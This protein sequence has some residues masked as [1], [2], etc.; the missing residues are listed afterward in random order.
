MFRRGS[1][2]L[3]F[4]AYALYYDMTRHSHARKENGFTACRSYPIAIPVTMQSPR[5]SKG[6]GIC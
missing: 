6:W 5:L 4:T 3:H 2:A 1:G